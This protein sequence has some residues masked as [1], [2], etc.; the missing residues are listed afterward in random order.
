[1]GTNF[2]QWSNEFQWI[3]MIFSSP[4]SERRTAYSSLLAAS[5]LIRPGTFYRDLGAKQYAQYAER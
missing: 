3:S 4:E 5:Q 1:M 2:I